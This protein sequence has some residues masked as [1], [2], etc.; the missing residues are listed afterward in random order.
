MCTLATYI[1]HYIGGSRQA[2]KQEKEKKRMERKKKNYLFANDMILYIENPKGFIK[3][4]SSNIAG[5]KINLQNQL[6]F[7]ILAMNNLK[8]KLRKQF[9]L[10]Q[11]QK[12]YN[13]MNTYE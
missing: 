5:Y 8:M 6:H 13:I 10:Q 3:N 11:H 2:V 1:Q 7:C 12:E 9:H 4:K